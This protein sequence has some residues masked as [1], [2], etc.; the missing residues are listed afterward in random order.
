[1][2]LHTTAVSPGVWHIQDAMGVCMTLIAGRDSAVLIDAGYGLEDVPAMVRSLTDLPVRLILAEAACEKLIG[3][4]LFSGVSAVRR[5][6]RY[7]CP[8][9]F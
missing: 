1:M 6:R 9:L 5:H 2:A 7:L 3:T 4:P 8:R